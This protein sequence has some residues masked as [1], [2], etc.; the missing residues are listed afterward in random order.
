M[1]VT[2]KDRQ[3]V[4][5][6]EVALIII[7]IY[8]YLG[9]LHANSGDQKNQRGHNKAQGQDTDV[10]ALYWEPPKWPTLIISIIDNTK[11]INTNYIYIFNDN[12]S[13]FGGFFFDIIT[14]V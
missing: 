12:M 2:A 4:S 10:V 11:L 5:S 1:D 14:G 7:N 13:R 3:R 6:N 9:V 8:I